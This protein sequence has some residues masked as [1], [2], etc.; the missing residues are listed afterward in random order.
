MIKLAV[1]DLD[2]TLFNAAHELDEQDA[3]IIKEFQNRGYQ[4]MIAT[5]R[6]W[7]N[8]KDLVEQFGI[9]CE[10]ICLN[11]AVILN[12]E[13]EMVQEIPIPQDIL[14]EVMTMLIEKDVCFHMYGKEGIITTDAKRCEKVALAHL[15]RNNFNEEEARSIMEK[16]KFAKFDVVVEDVDDYLQ[17]KPIVYK[18]E[19]FST[20]AQIQKEVRGAL[21]CIADIDVTNSVADNVEITYYKAQKGLALKSYCKMHDIA[22]DEVVVFGDSLNDLN[23]IETF[24]YGFAVE[25]A[26]D[27]IKEK[28]N[29]ITTSNVEHGVTR[30]LEGLME[31][32][33]DKEYLNN[34]KNTTK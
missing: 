34:F 11:G 28:A 4:F 32:N 2:G 21:S 14:K 3:N 13:R 15:M 17:S 10:Y 18:I 33:G 1:S 5:G 23:M 29:Y 12:E 26:I 31:H 24:H 6:N 20:T 19:L 16:G 22:M 9:T 8:A 25:N 7:T 30:I 27:C